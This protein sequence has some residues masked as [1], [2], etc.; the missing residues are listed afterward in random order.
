MGF[1]K[2]ISAADFSTAL[3]YKNNIYEK[4]TYCSVGLKTKPVS[5]K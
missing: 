4:T 2:K 5:S 1:I 3:T